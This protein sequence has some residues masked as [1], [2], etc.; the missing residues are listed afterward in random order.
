MAAWVRRLAHYIRFRLVPGDPL[1]RWAPTDLDLDSG[2]LL[3][4][5]CYRLPRLKGVGLTWTRLV[6]RH[7]FNRGLCIHEFAQLGPNYP[8]PRRRE[9]AQ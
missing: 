3:A 8:L 2:L 4:Q 1:V 6:V 5:G 9:R 7:P